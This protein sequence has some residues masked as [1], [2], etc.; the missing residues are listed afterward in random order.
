VIGLVGD[1]DLLVARNAKLDAHH[2]RN[3]AVLI[4]GALLDPDAARSQPAVQRFQL[5]DAGADVVLGPLRVLDIVEGEFQ[6]HLHGR[7][8]REVIVSQNQRAIGAAGS[9]ACRV[10]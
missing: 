6:R 10:G 5:A 9:R 3:G 1:N 8:L 4:V 7:Y 2:R